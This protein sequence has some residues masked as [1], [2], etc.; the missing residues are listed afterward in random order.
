MTPGA[1]V[2]ER[3]RFGRWVAEV[4]TLDSRRINADGSVTVP[5]SGYCA[6]GRTRRAAIRRAERFAAACTDGYITVTVGSPLQAD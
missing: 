3:M 5:V 6:A 4:P 2:V 1:T